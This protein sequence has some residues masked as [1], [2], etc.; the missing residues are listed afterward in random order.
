M[1][2]LEKAIL[3]AKEGNTTLSNIEL[4]VSK[5]DKEQTLYWLKRH[6]ANVFGWTPSEQHTLDMLKGLEKAEIERLERIQN[7]G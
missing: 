6:I 3:H 2:R 7:D 4:E 5:L 1:T